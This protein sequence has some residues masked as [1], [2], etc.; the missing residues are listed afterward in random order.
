MECEESIKSY[1][2]DLWGLFEQL[3]DTALVPD[4]NEIIKKETAT[5]SWIV[6]GGI[7]KNG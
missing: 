3:L 7:H 2:Q 1:R 6:K 5:D 4:W